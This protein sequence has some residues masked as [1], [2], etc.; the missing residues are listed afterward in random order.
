[1]TVVDNTND[2]DESLSVE[3][4]ARKPSRG[5][6]KQQPEV[7]DLDSP[8]DN[9]EH[10][11]LIPDF[12]R[13]AAHSIHA[14]QVY[15]R[16]APNEG[17]KGDVPPTTPKS[18]IGQRWGD[19]IYDF[20][21]VNQAGKTLRRNMSVKI[22]MGMPLGGAPPGA[23]AGGIDP[24]RSDFTMAEKLLSRQADQHDKDATRNQQIADKTLATVETLT[25]SYATMV[26]EDS[27][28]RI[29]R[30]REY[31]RHQSEQSERF[32]RNM[33][34]TMQTQYQQAMA[35]QREG[36]IM[37]IQMMDQSHR[38]TLALNNPAFIL[39]MFERG[40]KFGSEAAGD[41]DPVTAIVNAGM[42]GLGHMKD[43]M[44]LSKKKDPAK[45]PAGGETRPRKPGKPGRMSRE[46][47]LEVARLHK[48][49]EAKGY[50]FDAMISQA[51]GMLEQAPAQA[52]DDGEDEEDED[53]SGGDES[54]DNT[55]NRPP[56]VEGGNPGH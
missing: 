35:S 8:V 11:P 38:Q 53:E 39:Q 54:G 34:M 55:G 40:L 4:T 45:L 50:D 37:L 32:F 23:P 19:G 17:Y 43:M 52:P 42:Q 51:K 12:E 13:S 49:A 15:K 46:Q 22:A 56:G 2:D 18:F 5:R 31:F 21:A 10:I 30:D 3:V 27:Q 29:E 33:L 20:E 6:K 14:I 47:L 9:L 25:T 36:H 26:R 16:T 41:Q 7:E 24:A 28:A 44:A 48:I 1:M